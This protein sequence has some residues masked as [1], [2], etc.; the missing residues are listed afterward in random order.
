MNHMRRKS[1]SPQKN[2]KEWLQSLY[3]EKKKRSFELGVKSIDL[4]VKEGSSVSYRT[5]SD[6]SKEIDPEGKGIHQNTIRKN[7]ELYGY[8]LDHI[9]AK[10]DK[11]RYSSQ[12]ALKCD[13]D[14]FINI[15]EDR[16]IA[17]VK[18]RYMQLTKS[19]LVDIL[20]RMEQYIAHQNNHWVKNQFENFKN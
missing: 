18:Q 12:I 3:D 2:K 19:E 7:K 4:L 14:E 1:V 9:T 5:V 6:K 16:D 11:P 8:F 17:R 20:I 10:L 15:K 13:L